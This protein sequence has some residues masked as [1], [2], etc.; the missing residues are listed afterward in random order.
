MQK[1]LSNKVY[2]VSGGATGIGAAVKQ[3]LLARGDRVIVI[4]LKEGDI[5]ADLSSVEG[6]QRALEQV[7]QLTPEGLDGLVPCA[8]LGPHTKPVDLITRVNFFGSVSLI[9][10]LLSL[11]EKRRGC[12]VVISSNSAALP[13]YS[14]EYV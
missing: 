9:Q 4:D 10:G 1:N 5:L 11:L 12:I 13:G 6:R 14:P 3:K 2:V 8:G 7:Q